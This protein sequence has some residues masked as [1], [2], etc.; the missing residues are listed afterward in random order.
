MFSFYGRGCHAMYVVPEI[1]PKKTFP[2]VYPNSIFSIRGLFSGH[3]AKVQ[4]MDYSSSLTVQSNKQINKQ[5]NKQ[6]RMY[7]QISCLLFGQF[8][9]APYDPEV[10][11]VHSMTL[12]RVFL[13]LLLDNQP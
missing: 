12:I 3:E 6:K 5:T 4:L 1:G 10:L 8:L 9:I 2:F 7:L 11:L 13:R